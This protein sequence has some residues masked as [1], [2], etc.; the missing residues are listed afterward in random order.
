MAEPVLA[1]KRWHTNAHLIRDVSKLGYIVEPVYD[2]TPGDRGL[3]WDLS[4]WDVVANTDRGDFTDLSHI[5]DGIYRTVAF[6]PPYK[7]NGNPQGMAEM[8]TR[9]GIDVPSAWQDRRDLMER[10]FREMLR[11]CRTGGHVLVKCQDQ[12]CSGKIRWQTLWFVGWAEGRAELV[13]RFDLAG[14][15]IPQPME[16]RV[17]KHAHGRPSTLLVFERLTDPE[18]TLDLGNWA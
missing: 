16:G 1:Y 12:V 5:P 8:S 13:D 18:P 3:W 11:I 17:Q 7:L 9:Y 14:H 10:G 15:S 4:T 6:D 2:A